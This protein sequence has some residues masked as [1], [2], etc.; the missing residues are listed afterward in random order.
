[1]DPGLGRIVGDRM[2]QRKGIMI[3]RE[4]MVRALQCEYIVPH[5]CLR[6]LFLEII[7]KLRPGLTSLYC[8]FLLFFLKLVSCHSKYSSFALYI[9]NLHCIYEF[10]I[11]ISADFVSILTVEDIIPD[12]ANYSLWTVVI[13][14]ELCLVHHLI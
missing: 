6:K 11:G 2:Y 13:E 3:L 12:A 5:I 9:Q 7:H 10:I 4:Q 8:S 14:L 1:M